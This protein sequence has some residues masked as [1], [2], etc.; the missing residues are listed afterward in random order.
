M[1]SNVIG[2]MWITGGREND[3]NNALPPELYRK[4]FTLEQRP[5]KAMLRVSAL[6][7]YVAWINGRRVGDAYFT[8]G[9]T[10]YGSYIQYESYDVSDLLVTGENTIDV[11]VANGWYLGTI[12]AKNNNYGRMRAMLCELTDDSESAAGMSP[13]HPKTI[14]ESDLTWHVT[15]DT[16]VRYADFYNGETIDLTMADEDRWSWQNVSGFRGKIPTLKAHFGAFVRV[17]STLKPEKM[18]GNIY[19]FG[20][21]HSG[22]L[23]L[24]VRAAAGTKITIRHAEILANDGSLFTENLRGARQTLTLI[25][26][27]EEISE[28]SPS[29]TSMGFRYAEIH[30]DQPIDITVLE[31]RVLTA[32][33]E[34]IGSFICSNEQLNRLQ[35]NV[36][37]GQ[38][39]N[40]L[41]IPTDCPQ[42]D[43]RMGWTGDIAVFSETAA[44][45]R[46]I[47][48]FMRKWLYDMQVCQRDNGTIPVT[49]PEN[50]TYQPTPFKIPIAIW[51]D[52]ATMVPWAVYRAYG[53]RDFLAGQ[54]ASMKAY[55]KSEIRQAAKSGRGLEQYL[56]NNR[57]FQYGDWCAPGEGYNQWKR[58]GRYLATS[59][60]YNSV[61][62]VKEAAEAL[63]DQ[64]DVTYFSDV[65]AK[66]REAFETLEVRPDGTLRGDFASNYVCALYFHVVSERYRP[67]L[68]KRLAE[69]I[70]SKDYVIQT[71]FA[72]TPYVLFALADNGYVDDAYRVLLNEKCPGWLFTVNAGATT[73]WERW[74]ALDEKGNIRADSIPDMI[75]FNHYAYGS[76][77][78]FLY[79]RVLGLEPVKAGYQEF[80]IRPVL[81]GGLTKV[82]GG[83]KTRYGVIHVDWEITDRQFRIEVTVPDSTK[84]RL[85]L[86]DGTEQTLAGGQYKF[87]CA[88]PDGASDK[89]WPYEIQNDGSNN[90]GDQ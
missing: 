52:A 81:G 57:Q 33:C 85:L 74:D 84:C 41:E 21:N 89:R 87:S 53:D 80:L 9:Y 3:R 88:C 68:A 43:E 13:A 7:I 34:R 48:R 12:G 15:W 19:D 32:D 17:D 30:A 46:D 49:I 45:N 64:D 70:R 60:L 69:L 55:V 54:Y 67:A 4:M 14:V 83:E 18:R 72:G 77:G 25:C 11:V 79:R 38:M 59:Y 61:R 51:G 29:F 78:A 2:G 86:P 50:K 24:S 23:H 76:V 16:P 58:K 36:A 27:P 65:L 6:G 28:F 22:V 31:S 44:F 56:W 73:M 1:S 20:Q 90:T 26:G 82:S 71:G 5:E 62:I 40:F 66:I 39:A 63:A 8:P 35:Q 37:W 42:R 47:S 10:S 75:S